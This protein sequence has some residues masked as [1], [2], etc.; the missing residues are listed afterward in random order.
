MYLHA[1]I[2]EEDFY[3]GRVVMVISH[4]LEIFMDVA[5][6]HIIALKG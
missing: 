1:H 5:S 6:M 3:D 2:Y 4:S